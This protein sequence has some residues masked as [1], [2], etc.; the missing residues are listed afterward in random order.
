MNLW[1]IFAVALGAAGAVAVWFNLPL[2]LVL[3]GNASWMS[4]LGQQDEEDED[5]DLE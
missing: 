5:E 3:L 4:V 1:S 2:G